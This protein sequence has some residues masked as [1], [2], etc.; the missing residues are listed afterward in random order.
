Q[1]GDIEPP[2]LKKLT[3]KGLDAIVANPIDQ[4]GS[5]FGGDTNQAVLLGKLGQRQVIPASSKR[6]LAHHIFDFV[7]QL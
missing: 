4:P 6:H 7:G 1:T 5:G 3:S 2:A